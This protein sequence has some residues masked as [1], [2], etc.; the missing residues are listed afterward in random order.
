ML[1]SARQRKASV[2]NGS[3]T[4]GRHAS[5]TNTVDRSRVRTRPSQS[6]R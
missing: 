5:S 4:V 2:P 6:Q 1:M 3:A